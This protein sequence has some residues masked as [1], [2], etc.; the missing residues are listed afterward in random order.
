MFFIC[1]G[2]TDLQWQ[3]NI[4]RPATKLI[5]THSHMQNTQNQNYSK[6]AAVYDNKG[7]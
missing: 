6:C 2:Q 5:N 1:V 4:Q 3:Y 7:C